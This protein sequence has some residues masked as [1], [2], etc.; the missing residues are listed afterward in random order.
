MLF[1]LEVAGVTFTL[2]THLG[3]SRI[4]RTPSLPDVALLTVAADR[5]L[6]AAAA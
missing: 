1:V 6:L 3:S 2:R 4:R 5:E